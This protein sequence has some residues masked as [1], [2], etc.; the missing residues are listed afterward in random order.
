MTVT[1]A[2]GGNIGQGRRPGPATGAPAPA[3]ERDEQAAFW[4]VHHARELAYRRRPHVERSRRSGTRT[5]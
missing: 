1:R 4:R 5:E 2:S 3:T